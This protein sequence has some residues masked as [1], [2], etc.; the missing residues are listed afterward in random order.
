MRA[1]ALAALLTAG[2]ATTLSAPVAPPLT[3]DAQEETLR[4]RVGVVDDPAVAALLTRVTSA[5]LTAEDGPAPVELVVLRDPTLAAFALPSGRIYLHTGV[6]ARLENEAQLA[7]VLARALAL[8]ARRAALDAAPSAD[9]MQDTLLAMPAAV[10]TTLAAPEP[11]I[12]VLSP[13]AAAVL[14]HRLDAVHT[15]AVLGY[16]R[17]VEAEAD[18]GA[19][20]RL[21]HAGYDPSEA[22]RTFE[23]F[24]R[25]ARAGGAI[26]RFV[27][28]R[29][30]VL[31]ARV[32]SLAQLLATRGASAEPG[33]TE[34]APDFAP[35]MAVVARENAR[36]ELGVGRFRAAQ[37]Q[38]D[39]A[40][41]AAPDD[42]R[43][44]LALGDLYR[45]RGQRARGAAERDE[46]AR[47]ALHAY[48]RAAR[49]D[50]GLRDVARQIGLLYYQQG[51]LARAREAFARYLASHPDAP[52]APRV[53]EY[54]A[55]L[56]P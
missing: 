11:A 38:L 41:V 44:H 16:G 50:P 56:G 8:R 21:A 7:T 31:A 34:V 18:A 37:D 13:T 32:Q 17:D 47:H 15:V 48:E 6:L 1:L 28:G 2:C 5:L 20:R 46:L 9:A 22:A 12:A 55:A 3:L 24:R 53:R 30:A 49:L 19:L 25:E 39:R 14:G 4:G 40:I 33:G 43:T 29:D 27:L 45:L 42:A 23:R 26:E 52:D 54:L 36:L 10:A 35:A 51:Q